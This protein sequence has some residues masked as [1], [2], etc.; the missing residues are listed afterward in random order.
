MRP[1]HAGKVMVA[2]SRTTMANGSGTARSILSLLSG[3]RLGE[4]LALQGS[5]LLGAFF[6]I[7]RITTERGVA[8]LLLAARSCWLVAHVFVLNDWCGMRTDLQDPNRTTGVF[9]AKGIGPSD[10]G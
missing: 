9:T 5:P 2:T 7:G 6:S 3:I 4:V 10:I 8:L 1:Q